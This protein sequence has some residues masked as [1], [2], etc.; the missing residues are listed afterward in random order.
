MQMSYLLGFPTPVV[1]ILLVLIAVFLACAFYYGLRFEG[2]AP[3]RYDRSTET[4]VSK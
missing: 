3:I 1:E 2:V 4:E